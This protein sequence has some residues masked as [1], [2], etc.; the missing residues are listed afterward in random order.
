MLRLQKKLHRHI[1]VLPEHV[2]AHSHTHKRDALH[3]LATGQPVLL[4]DGRVADD[5]HEEGHNKG[6]VRGKPLPNR[7]GHRCNRRDRLLSP[8]A[9]PAV[10][11]VVE[12]LHEPIEV[13]LDHLRLRV[14]AEVYD[15]SRGVHA[16]ADRRLLGGIHGMRQRR[17]E[18]IAVILLQIRPKVCAHLPNAVERRPAHTWVR[19]QNPRQHHLDNLR[20]VLLHLPERPLPDL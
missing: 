14:L 2:L 6:V 13:W 18:L 7:K 19:V 10:Q 9:L 5:A 15:G 3:G 1:G 11:Q 16:H 17:Q 20:E 4:R 12:L 8:L